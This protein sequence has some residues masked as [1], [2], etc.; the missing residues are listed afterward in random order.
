MG[1]GKDLLK[2]EVVELEMAENTEAEEELEFGTKAC[3]CPECGKE[4]PHRERGVPCSRLKCPV[5]G[6]S[7]KGSQCRER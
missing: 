7:M 2:R 4:L 6:S 3:V 1:G 5:C